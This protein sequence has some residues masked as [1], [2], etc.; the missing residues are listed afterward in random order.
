MAIVKT[1]KRVGV[2]EP[3][4]KKI[5]K[6]IV[7]KITFSSNSDDSVNKINEL[8]INFD[9]SDEDEEISIE[10]NINGNKYFNF[11]ISQLPHCCGINEIGEFS[12]T[13]GFNIKQLTEILDL[14]VSNSG[15]GKT[16]IINTNGRESSIMLEEALLKC[17]RWVLVKSFI[18]SNSKNTVKMWI[19]NN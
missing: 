13:N 7:E 17:K 12:L 15:S 4:T 19:S 1:V 8:T 2:K 10:S 11:S 3:I 16:A 5:I 18:N 14:L 6:P 9:D